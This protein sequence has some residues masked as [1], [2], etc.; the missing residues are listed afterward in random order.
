[1]DDKKWQI[2]EEFHFGQQK[3]SNAQLMY[4][5]ELLMGKQFILKQQEQSES[6]LG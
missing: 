5:L 4:V 6:Q 3:S 2:R 1:M